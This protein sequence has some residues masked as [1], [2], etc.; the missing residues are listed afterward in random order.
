MDWYF[1]ERME[2]NKA[3]EKVKKDN[4]K[5]R[6]EKNRGQ[7]ERVKIPLLPNNVGKNSVNDAGP[8]QKVKCQN[9]PPK[10]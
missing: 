3:D 6:G 5:M 9:Q 10:F 4:I 2:T 7:G 1:G 8:K